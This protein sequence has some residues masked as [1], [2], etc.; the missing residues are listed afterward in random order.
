MLSS[1]YAKAAC[2]ESHKHINIHNSLSASPPLRLSCLPLFS[3]L[4]QN[5]F[6]LL[7]LILLGPYGRNATCVFERQLLT[8]ITTCCLDGVRVRVPA[9]TLYRYKSN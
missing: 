4:H 6:N 5:S 1:M 2:D 9:G 3:L 8:F 7:K